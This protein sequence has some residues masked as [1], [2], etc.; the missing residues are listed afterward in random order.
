MGDGAEQRAHEALALARALQAAWCEF[1]LH[2]LNL[3]LHLRR[4]A[5]AGRPVPEGVG[6]L[7]ADL[8]AQLG[9]VVDL[10]AQLVARKEG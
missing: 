7:V 8:E 1:E 5:L 10:E 4:A 9:R 2:L 3:R 6:E